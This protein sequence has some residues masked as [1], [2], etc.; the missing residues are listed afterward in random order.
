MKCLWAAARHVQVLQ[1]RETVT[2]GL[3]RL[4][5]L[6]GSSSQRRTGKRAGANAPPSKAG[7]AQVAATPVEQVGPPC[8]RLSD[9]RDGSHDG[10]DMTD[11]RWSTACTVVAHDTCWSTTV[12]GAALVMGAPPLLPHAVPPAH[13]CCWCLFRLRQRRTST[14]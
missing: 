1:P 10:H 2:G 7:T 3:K 5:A 12:P 4:G 13:C 11:S 14:A 9:S 6:S 8:R